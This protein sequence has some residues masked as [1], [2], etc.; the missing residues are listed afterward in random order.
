MGGIVSIGYSRF[1]RDISPPHVCKFGHSY[2]WAEV[3]C[4]CGYQKSVVAVCHGSGASLT[5]KLPCDH[6][7]LEERQR[8]DKFDKAMRAFPRMRYADVLKEEKWRVPYPAG[9][10]YQE[11]FELSWLTPDCQARLRAWWNEYGDDILNYSP[12]FAPKWAGA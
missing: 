12:S 2:A 4:E 9:A 1:A 10:H 3:P 5:S 11:W 7:T 6:P 8:R